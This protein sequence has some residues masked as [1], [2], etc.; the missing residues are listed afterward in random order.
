MDRLRLREPLDVRDLKR[1]WLAALGEARRLIDALPAAE[2]G[3]LY[4]APDGTPTTPDPTNAGFRSLRRHFGSVR[5][6]WPSVEP[7]RSDPPRKHS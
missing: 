5:G 6:A 2:V 7:Y 1:Q 4:L 3:C